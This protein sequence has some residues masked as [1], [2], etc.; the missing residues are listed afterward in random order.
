MLLVCFGLPCRIAVLGAVFKLDIEKM[1]RYAYFALLEMTMVGGQPQRHQG[2]CKT[3]PTA[4]RNVG[5]KAK[6]LQRIS[7][8]CDTLEDVLGF[9]R[10][11]NI[12]AS[13]ST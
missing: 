10:R 2:S 5:G 7:F 11:F 4:T 1:C 9:D 12:M 8:R 3:R 13:N 6:V